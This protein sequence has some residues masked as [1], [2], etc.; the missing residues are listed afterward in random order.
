MF[1]TNRI[2]KATSNKPIVMKC[3]LDTGA[4]VNV[5][6]LSAYQYVNLSEF[7]V[8]GKPTGGYGQDRITLKGYNGNCIKQCGI[9]S[10]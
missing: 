10:F 9:M 8:Q 4:G 1:P 3:K 5:M 2:G 6:P 7:D